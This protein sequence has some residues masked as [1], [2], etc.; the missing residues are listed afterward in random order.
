MLHRI[1]PFTF[2]DKVINN[3]GHE[4]CAAPTF[5]HPTHARTTRKALLAAA[6]SPL[7]PAPNAWNYH[8]QFGESNQMSA[9]RCER[10]ARGRAPPRSAP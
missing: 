3:T 6:R 7:L 8:L 4:R 1:C 10:A 2:C 5:A 9:T